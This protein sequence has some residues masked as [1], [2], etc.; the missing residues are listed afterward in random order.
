MEETFTPQHPYT[1]N[2]DIINKALEITGHK[3]ND[4]AFARLSKKQ[5]NND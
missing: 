4:E 3:V 5:S 2:E 1:R